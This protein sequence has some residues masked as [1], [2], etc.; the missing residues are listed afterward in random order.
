MLVNKHTCLR[1]TRV[2][3]CSRGS[4][5]VDLESKRPCKHQH[6]A[7]RKRQRIRRC[8]DTAS[9]APALRSQTR[10]PLTLLPFGYHT[11]TVKWWSGKETRQ[12]CGSCALQG[13][14]RA[15]QDACWRCRMSRLAWMSSSS[16]M[17]G[18]RV[19]Y[20]PTTSF[21]VVLM[22]SRLSGAGNTALF[23]CRCPHSLRAFRYSVWRERP[24]VPVQ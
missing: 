16:G 10:H 20:A 15:V 6:L 14:G 5:S 1:Q 12:A 4:L 7:E 9:L 17:R 8:L 18:Q 11:V 24:C 13:G 2:A 22:I 3:C 19:R 23:P 21:S